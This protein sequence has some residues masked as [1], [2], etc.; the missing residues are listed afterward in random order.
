ML[1]APT[2]MVRSTEETPVTYLNKNQTYSIYITDTA[3]RRANPIASRYRTAIRVAFEDEHQ[4]SAPTDAWDLWKEGRGKNEAY[5]RSGRLQAIEFVRPESNHGGHAIQPNVQLVNETFDGF[6]V[7]WTPNFSSVSECMVQA[8][9]HF[10]STDFSHSKGVKGFPLRLCAKT[11]VV[12]PGPHMNGSVFPDR[13]IS[14]CI[15]KTFRDHGSERKLQNDRAHV[16][17]CVD[18]VRLQIEESE[19]GATKAGGSK[20][21]RVDSGNTPRTKVAKHKRDSSATSIDSD[22]DENMAEGELQAKIRTYESMTRSMRPVSFLHIAG[23][24]SDDLDTHPVVLRDLDA[25]SL[26]EMANPPVLLRES[27]QNTGSSSNQSPPASAGMAFASPVNQA[28]QRSPQSSS[29]V[30]ARRFS[31][32]NTLNPQQF[33]SPMGGPVKVKTASEGATHRTSEWIDAVDVDATYQPPA[34]DTK[35]VACFYVKASIAGRP[36]SD[37]YYRAIYLRQRSVSSLVHAIA[38]KYKLGASRVVD[39]IRINVTGLRVKM[40]DEL[41]QQM[42]EGQDF[43]ADIDL[44]DETPDSAADFLH[45]HEEGSGQ[46]GQAEGYK[47]MLRF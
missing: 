45:G 3:A 1:K 6:S 11:E 33:A 29:F 32:I 16:K 23:D 7:E 42:N 46:S 12:D 24:E 35:P 34:R 31:T 27:T 18:K 40:D 38:S 37:D 15:V 14:Y 44:A 10:L 22:D 19:A 9:F 20:R 30:K 13:E 39:V 41:V 28:F 36:C 43:I 2:A 47:I 21:L 8:R 4:R 5:K 17:K 25:S 26:A